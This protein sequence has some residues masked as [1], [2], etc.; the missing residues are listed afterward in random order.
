MIQYIFFLSTAVEFFYEKFKSRM[1]MKTPDYRGKCRKIRTSHR[2]SNPRTL[3]YGWAIMSL[4]A[5]RDGLVL[6]GV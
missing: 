3:G 5:N 4:I 2:G 1:A 6:E